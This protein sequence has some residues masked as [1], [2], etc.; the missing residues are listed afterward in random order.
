MTSATPRSGV[1]AGSRTGSAGTFG[2]SNDDPIMKDAP[3]AAAARHH[4]DA[5]NVPQEC[6]MI[7]R[8]VHVSMCATCAA[9]RR[10]V[11]SERAEGRVP[12][13]N[14]HRTPLPLSRGGAGV[15]VRAG[16]GGACISQVRLGTRQRA[17]AAVL[18]HAA[19][20]HRRVRLRGR[21][22]TQRRAGWMRASRALFAPAD[23][24]RRTRTALLTRHKAFPAR[25][26]LLRSPPR[27]FSC[28]SGDRQMR[29]RLPA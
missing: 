23:R 4:S 5:R 10:A 15:G 26:R 11:S 1:A 3:R 24:P 22:A 21:P 27:R 2:S 17:C 6:A 7:D 16:T 12:T 14:H 25:W 19:R 13:R 9:R 29:E 18:I 28:S 20:Q 8:V